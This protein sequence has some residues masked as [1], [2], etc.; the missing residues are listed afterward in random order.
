VRADV[1]VVGG[2]PVGLLLGCRLEQLGVECAVLES[3][4]RGCGSRAIGIHPPSLEILEGLGLVN[5]FLDEGVRIERAHAFSS[6]RWLGS[7]DLRRAHARY[8]FA[9]SLPQERT[10]AILAARLGARLHRGVHVVDVE[11]APGGVDVVTEG[12]RWRGRW[13]VGCDGRHGVVAAAMGATM[14]GSSAAM[15][16][17]MGDFADDTA[18]GTDAAIFL[19]DDGLVE[20]FPLPNGQR[21]WVAEVPGGRAVAE[22]RALAALVRRRTG[23]RL[24]PDTVSM[25]SAF[26]I[27][28]LMATHV[29]ARG[30]VL[31]GDAAHVV[32]PFGGQGMN[33]GWRDA[34]DLGGCLARIS[35]GA[36]AEE[37]ELS[38]Y[39][40]R[41]RL[42]ARRA[43]RRA[44]FNARVGRRS[45]HP[46]LRNAAALAML[47]C[48]PEAWLARF[49]TMGSLLG[50]R[51]A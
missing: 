11:L 29:V 17:L 23:E 19:G 2:G 9:L 41:A 22:C 16:C 48:V 33:V 14:T 7:V 44:A 50:R 49:F 34:W 24:R 15:C 6:H 35:S 31:A 4:R 1:V 45:R 47:R 46:R 3:R 28:Q 38:G 13:A 25:L 5:A 51:A 21:R 27:E 40:R 18:L 30:R 20:S 32:S 42:A 37:H 36:V 39:E 12:E 8:G 26:G 43:I 10:E